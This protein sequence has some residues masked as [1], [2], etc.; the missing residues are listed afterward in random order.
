MSMNTHPTVEK[1]QR[2]GTKRQTNLRKMIEKSAAASQLAAP[3][4]LSYSAST[5][6]KPK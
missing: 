4:M 2:D 5:H 1:A 6:N 3:Q